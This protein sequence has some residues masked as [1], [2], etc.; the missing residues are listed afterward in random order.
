MWFSA[1]CTFQEGQKL[2]TTKEALGNGQ[3]GCNRKFN[4]E[5]QL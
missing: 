5:L 1:M 2:K 4:M 3:D